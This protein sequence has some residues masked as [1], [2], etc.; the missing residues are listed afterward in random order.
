[1][2]EASTNEFQFSQSDRIL[3]DTTYCPPRRICKL[4]AGIAAEYIGKKRLRSMWS[5]LVL[6]LARVL[7][8]CT[9]P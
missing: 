2:V 3:A 5:G 1:M 6:A 9:V 8:H 7:P 4:T